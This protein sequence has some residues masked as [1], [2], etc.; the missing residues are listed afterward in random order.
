MYKRVLAVVALAAML[1]WT[2]AMAD[3]EGD[4]DA[5]VFVD[6]VANIAV[7][8][9][10]ANVDLGEIQTGPFPGEIIF[11]IDANVE[12]VE[13]GVIASNL[14]KGDAN[15][16]DFSIPV[17]GD[18]ANVQP[19]MGNAVEGHGNLLAWLDGNG[20]TVLLNGMEA[21]E[22]ETWDFESGQNGHFSQDVTVSLEYN[23]P[24]P[25]LPQGEYSGW[26]KLVAAV[27]P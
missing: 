24:D 13:I 26:V 4:A 1:S 17:S 25:E 11:R 22:S 12:E 5:H 9:V 20:T 3:L 19:D 15:D 18:G 16:S 23:Q 6:V 10:T 27:Q 2:P 8:V 14:Y 21:L 7:G